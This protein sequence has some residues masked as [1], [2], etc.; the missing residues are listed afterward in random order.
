[1]DIEQIFAA[2]VFNAKRTAAEYEKSG[3]HQTVPD[4]ISM[5]LTDIWAFYSAGHF[6]RDHID[7]IVEKYVRYDADD[8]PWPRDDIDWSSAVRAAVTR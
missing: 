1:M 5:A 7:S 6:S 2:E 8:Q 4:I 3:V